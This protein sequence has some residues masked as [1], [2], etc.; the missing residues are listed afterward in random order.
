MKLQKDEMIGKG[1]FNGLFV[2][3]VTYRFSVWQAVQTSH[4]LSS[5]VFHQHGLAL[6][7]FVVFRGKG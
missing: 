2:G 7:H 4:V 5:A 1:H 3:H 6:G